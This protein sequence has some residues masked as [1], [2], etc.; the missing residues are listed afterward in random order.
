MGFNDVIGRFETNELGYL[1]RRTS[2]ETNK[3]KSEIDSSDRTIKAL[4][5]FSKSLSAQITHDAKERIKKESAEAKALAHEQHLELLENEGIDDIPLEEKEE[6][7][8]SVAFLG[9]THQ[10]FQSA[11]KMVLD[12]GGTF[13]DSK[14][15]SNLSGWALY[16]FTSE[17]AAIAANNYPA[18]LEGQMSQ[19]KDLPVTLDGETFTPS[20]A[21]TIRQKNAAM[22]MLR[23]QYLIDRE[24][25]GANRNILAEEDGFYDKAMVAHATLMSKYHAQY[26][27]EQSFKDK[28][29]AIRRFRH[30]K[31]F[32]ELFS[33]L[34]TLV[35]DKNVPLNYGGAI[36]EGFDIVQG[37]MDIGEFDEDDLE[38]FGEQV[39]TV[40]GK[41]RLIKNYWHTRYQ[42]LKDHLID[43]RNKQ[44]KLTQKEK[45]ADFLEAETR[46]INDLRQM[47]DEEL[48]E[49][50]LLEKQQ[51]L[52]SK[53]IGFRSKKLDNFI[54][55]AAPDAKG[56]AKHK[57][58][59]EKLLRYGLLT[60]EKLREF[61]MRHWKAYS[62]A[63]KEISK[64]K[65]KTEKY[66]GY[67]EDMVKFVGKLNAGGL[68]H[69]SV[70]EMVDVQLGRYQELY[71]DALAAGSPNPG[72]DAWKA[73]QAEWGDG[74]QYKYRGGFKTSK[75][76]V[77]DT[78]KSRKA[79]DTELDRQDKLLKDQGKKALL[80]AEAFITN[81]LLLENL[82]TFGTPGW[83]PPGV[84]KRLK[85]TFPTIDELDLLKLL[86]K[87]NGV[88]IKLPDSPAL[89][90]IKE[91]TKTED[92]V[93]LNHG[94]EQGQA[95][96]LGIT[97][98]NKGSDNIELVPDG[99]GDNVS[100]VA[101]D[102][103]IDFGDAAASY[104]IFRKYP[105]IARKY[106][107]EAK[108]FLPSESGEVDWDRVG[109]AITS[110]AL[111]VKEGSGLI[112]NA[113]RDTLFAI[114]DKIGDSY[115]SLGESIT[116]PSLELNQQ[117]ED[118]LSGLPD[119]AANF[120]R[121]SFVKPILDTPQILEDE[122]SDAI[123]NLVNEVISRGPTLDE[124]QKTE[125][126][127]A[128][129]KYTGNI[130]YAPLRKE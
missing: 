14:K 26:A 47:P 45:E 130:D 10:T 54:K 129:Y 8:D 32:T 33:T 41:P 95:R 74:S 127:R 75:L 18:W 73:I 105:D 34:T 37:Q 36:K 20:T 61:D 94:G 11:S 35:D 85:Q 58:E 121:E 69:P 16:T 31:D 76:I 51:E 89:Q 30:T 66:R 27:V 64:Q 119:D 65:D 2:L 44:E 109:L 62:G 9:A 15:I 71:G 6:H 87:A 72:E 68:A 114:R 113:Y 23:Q 43:A 17:K 46:L 55:F 125:F 1:D 7:S 57:V 3:L 98:K 42:G 86:A 48:T 12:N 120:I 49:G 124:E 70:A 84:V 80:V 29:A 99:E 92:K 116:T 104:E 19:N 101:T 24:L 96:V 5:G 122:A 123:N 60:E 88:D 4:S 83:T 21:K 79:I 63:A 110:L 117:I 102:S 103:G 67:V 59:I 81:E 128:Q 93:V 91:N 100:K 115:Q 112:L 53:H 106:G 28:E 118:A 50:K 39:I 90:I 25:I 82:E 107:I 40:D 78:H 111:N 77:S 97:A 56:L 13:D 52:E 108:D 22:K 38:Y 126:A